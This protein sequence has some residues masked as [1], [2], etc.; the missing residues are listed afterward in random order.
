MGVTDL[1]FGN[2]AI[3]SSASAARTKSA[4]RLVLRRAPVLGRRKQLAE[5][6]HAPVSMI[7]GLSR[8]NG[9]PGTAS[10]T[11]QTAAPPVHLRAGDVIC[12][13]RSTTVL[14]ILKSRA[15][16]QTG[17]H[18]ASAPDL[19]AAAS[20][21]PIS[22]RR[23]RLDV[24][25][26]ADVVPDAEVGDVVVERVAR[27]IATP[28]VLIDAAVDVVA[29]NAALRVVGRVVVLVIGRSAERGDL[30]DLS[31]PKRTWASRKRRPIRSTVAEQRTDLLGRRVGRH[32]EVLGM[33]ADQGIAH[34]AAHQEGLVARL[35]QPIQHL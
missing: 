34:A 3:G 8:R 1:P 22:T 17:R 13:W 32:V 28:H 12:A 26:A 14:S 21:S 29:N 33:Q 18:A 11:H 5:Q 2:A 9:L 35:V 7:K 24:L 16:R 4:I 10:G 20:G 30:Y 15:W 27:E 6:L 31:R 19:R 25:D 23:R